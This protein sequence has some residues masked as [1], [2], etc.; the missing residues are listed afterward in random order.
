MASLT[1][2]VLRVCAKRLRPIYLQRTKRQG[3]EKRSRCIKKRERNSNH[4]AINGTR[5]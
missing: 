5:V 1:G 2:N 4:Y 3:A